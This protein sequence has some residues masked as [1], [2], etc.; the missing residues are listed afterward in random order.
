MHFG[1]SSASIVSAGHWNGLSNQKWRLLP[2]WYRR[3]SEKS[4]D[5]TQNGLAAYVKQISEGGYWKLSS[6]IELALGVPVNC[7]KS[8]ESIA[9]V[10]EVIRNIAEQTNF[11]WPW[12]P[13][14]EAARLRWTRSWFCSLLM[15]FRTLATRTQDSTNWNWIHDWAKLKVTCGDRICLKRFKKQS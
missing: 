5:L 2:R 3:W 13:T 8:S 12:T 10:L 7:R 4:N 1:E 11:I 9:S 15:K 14:I 6:D